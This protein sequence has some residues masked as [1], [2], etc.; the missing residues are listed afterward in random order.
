M[1]K[2]TLLTGSLVAALVV[3]GCDSTS[4]PANNA[5]TP[6]S[7]GPVPTQVAA[8]STTTAEAYQAMFDQ[9]SSPDLANPM[10]ANAAAVAS[11]NSQLR[12]AYAANPSDS[13]TAFALAITSL[14]LKLNDMAGTF[15]RAQQNG[16]TIGG[17][18]TVMATTPDEVA[19]NLPVLARALAVP[20]KAPLVH[21]LQDSLEILLMPSL[22]EAITLLGKAWADPAF[23]F[24]VAIDPANFPEDTLI[25]DRSDVGFALSILQAVRAQAR[26][27]LSYN[28][29]FDQSG[30][31]TWLDTLANFDPDEAPISPAQN[32]ALE[33]LK[34]L[35]APGSSFLKVRASKT[36]L[37]ASV[38]GE[39]KAALQRAREAG[40]L[41]YTL[42]SNSENHIPTISTEQERDDFTR[43]VDSA[44]RWFSGPVRTTLYSKVSCKDSSWSTDTWNGQTS[45]TSYINT[46]DHTALLGLGDLDGCGDNDYDYV[47][48]GYEYHSRTLQG[49]TRSQTV[50]FDITKLLTLTDLKVFV[51]RYQWNATANWKADGPVS[52]VGSDNIAWTASAIDSLSTFDEVK[53]RISWTDPTFGGTFPELTTSGAVIELFRKAAEDDAP[54]T[55]A[56]RGPLALF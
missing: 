8:A 25:I 51:P 41:A 49:T 1:K 7:S 47:G 34:S 42:K 3:A 20:A 44:L 23:E 17:G 52:L 10:G 11:A 33:Q 6:A 45:T 35:V 4:S 50:V 37:L 56:A 46:W 29:D 40:V 12:S 43:V 26:W 24:H 38:P 48:D 18:T 30:S 54:A 19:G 5:A 55:V 53:G 2:F 13:R 9:S 16:L 21:E 32:T 27:V 36:E 28:F 15:D 31:Y 14:S 22:D 39:L